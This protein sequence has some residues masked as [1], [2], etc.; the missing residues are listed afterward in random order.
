MVHGRFGRMKV[1]TVSVRY[2]Q[3]EGSGKLALDYTGVF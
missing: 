2:S 1:L 3:L